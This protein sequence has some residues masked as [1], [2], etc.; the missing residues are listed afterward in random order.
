MDVETETAMVAMLSASLVLVKPASM[1][2]KEAKDWIMVAYD[3]LCHLPLPIFEQGVRSARLICDHPSKIVPAVVA[4]TRDALAWHNSR[5]NGPLLRL[6]P[7]TRPAI[8]DDLPHPDTLMPSLK[9]MGLQLGWIVEGPH[10]LE[11]SKETA[12]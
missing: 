3:S 8:S 6:V 9:R 7:P 11:W 2:P 5:K 12:A 1:T 4:Q 10:G